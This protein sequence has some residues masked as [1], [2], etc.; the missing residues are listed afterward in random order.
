MIQFWN[1]GQLSKKSE[2]AKSL[3]H[4]RAV[5]YGMTL[6]KN[7]D[8]FRQ[9]GLARENQWTGMEIL[10]ITRSMPPPATA[11]LLLYTML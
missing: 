1:V 3:E 2:H 9:K 5:T 4:F 11:A 6:G 8:S 10:S 7:T